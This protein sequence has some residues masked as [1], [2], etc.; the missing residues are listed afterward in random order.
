M[1]LIWAE[2]QLSARL[3]SHFQGN[4]SAATQVISPAL[5]FYCWDLQAAL[6]SNNQNYKAILSLSQSS[7]KELAWWRDDLEQFMHTIS[8]ELLAAILAVNTLLKDASAVILCGV[9]IV[10]LHTIIIITVTHYHD[11]R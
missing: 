10:Q 4:L 6:V 5:L 7:Q 3:L 11:N 9:M 1:K 8:L 2:F